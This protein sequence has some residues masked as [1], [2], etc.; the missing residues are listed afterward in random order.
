MRIRATTI[1]RVFASFVLFATFVVFV[2]AQA[3]SYKVPRTPDGQPDLQGFW[4]NATYTPLERPDNVSKEFYTPAE[5]AAVEKAAASRETEQ[6]EPGTTADVHYD[7]TQF[8]LDRSQA[9]L[10][11][12]LRTSLIVDPKNGKL[13]PIT[14]EGKKI[15]A[16]RAE[17]AKKLG[18]RWDS[19]Q[20][21]QLDDRCLIMAGSGPPM[22]DAAY[23]SNYH[24][25]QAPGYVMILTEMIHDA[26]IIPLDSRPQ[27]SANVRQWVGLSRGHWEGDTLVVETTNFNGKN[28]FRGSTEHM[29]VI[30]RLRRVADDTIE[31]NFTVDDKS[32]WERAWSAEAVMRKTTGPLFEHACHEGNYGLY[33]TLVGARLEEQKAAEGA[34]KK[35]SK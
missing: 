31:Y 10:A 16:A 8:G 28:P 17:E 29:K 25:V 22:M 5:A 7:F 2:S 30:E 19:A 23:N 18:G 27:P 21:N 26:R 12:T 32:M 33:N 13:P 1:F 14:P 15:L 11:R 6:T 35:D 9:T 24:I 4:S 34:A 20:A 3:P